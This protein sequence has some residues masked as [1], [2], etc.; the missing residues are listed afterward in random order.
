L[1]DTIEELELCFFFNLELNDLPSSIK[2][3]IF[4]KRSYYNKSLNNLPKTVELLE[5]P[6]KYNLPI[7]N[8]P[9]KLKSI[10]CSKDYKF[11]DEF[12]N[13]NIETY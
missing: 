5:L 13:F 1:P 7:I 8:I 11:I 9:Q 4:N 6:S 2:K 3:I 12:T 10:I